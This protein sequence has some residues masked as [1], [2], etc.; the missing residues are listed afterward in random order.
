MQRIA[1]LVL[2]L[3]PVLA[4]AQ[5]MDKPI[6]GSKLKDGSYTLYFNFGI[7]QYENNKK[8]DFRL[9]NWILN[10][11]YPNEYAE[12]PD[13]TYCYLNRTVYDRI[14]TEDIGTTVTEHFHSEADRNLHLQPVDWTNGKLDFTIRF[15][16]GNTTEVMIR[17]KELGGILY[18]DSFKALGV[19]RGFWSDSMSALEYRIPEYTYTLNLPIRF[20]GIKSE[21]D[22]RREEFENSLSASD[23][24]IW[25]AKAE[26]LFREPTE[27]EE[28]ELLKTIP[29]YADLK[30][31]KRKATP[32]EDRLLR[33]ALVN[34]MMKNVREIGLSPDGT[35]RALK[36][37]EGIFKK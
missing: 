22:K 37:M 14:L 29:G 27:E 2:V 8:A 34:M 16:D 36:F 20:N 18:M 21:D 6:I 3:V 24:A 5:R 15:T 1:I 25:L 35:V 11:S 4:E 7:E 23:R 9:Q 28:H 32:E 17:L 26:T 30:A 13:K 19:A 12:R 33:Q 10:C 31:E